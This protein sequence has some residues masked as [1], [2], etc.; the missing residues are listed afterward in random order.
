MIKKLI[1]DQS[2][3]L[4]RELPTSWP[5]SIS[6]LSSQR[7]SPRY[8]VFQFITC[9]QQKLSLISAD[10]IGLALVRIGEWPAVRG[11]VSFPRFCSQR[12]TPKHTVSHLITFPPVETAF[13]PS[14][15]P[16]VWFKPHLHEDRSVTQLLLLSCSLQQS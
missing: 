16:L 11:T 1:K 15:I 10:F 9:P 5:V 4:V 2:E 8:T 6:K 7:P 14:R 3:K 13:H 12:R